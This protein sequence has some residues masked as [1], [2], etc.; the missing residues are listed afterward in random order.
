MKDELHIISPTGQKVKRVQ[1]DFVGSISVATR[2]DQSWFF[3]HCS[4]FTNPGVVGKF[5]FLPSKDFHGEGKWSVQRTV[6]LKGLV[7]DDFIAEQVRFYYFLLK[8]NQ[9]LN[10]T[11]R[12]GTRARMERKSLCLLS[13]ISL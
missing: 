9:I 6:Q 10:I 5:D 7:L 2:R 12:F 11:L 4:G 1:E 13:A 8:Y 3:A